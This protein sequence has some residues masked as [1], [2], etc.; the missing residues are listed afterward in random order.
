MWTVAGGPG[1]NF[2]TKMD[3][4]PQFSINVG[5]NRTFDT[6]A[7]KKARPPA[8]NKAEDGPTPHIP[9]LSA[10]LPLLSTRHASE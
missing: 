2:V 10:P 1:V 7:L 5:G 8:S 9:T 6:A 4:P 3:F